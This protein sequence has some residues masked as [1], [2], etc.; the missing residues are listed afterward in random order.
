MRRA[1]ELAAKARGMTSPNPMVGAVLVKN[2]RVIGEGYHHGP[3]LPHAEIDAIANAS[4]DVAGATIYVTLEPCCHEGKTP[5]CTDALIRHKI[6]RVVAAT[7]DPNP[8]VCK[9]GFT[10]LR[11][12]G[13]Q[14]DVGLCE[15]EA[16]LLNEVFITSHSLRRPFIIAKW[17]MT[18]DGKIATETGHSRWITND[19]SRGYVHE[20]RSQVDAIMVGIGTVLVDNP[21]LNV[22][23]ENYQGRQPKCIIMDGA[24]R[25]P[26][27][28][29]CLQSAPAGCCI[30][31]T[32]QSA[33]AEKVAQLRDAGHQVLVLRGRRGLLDVRDLIRELH[34]CGIQSILAE[35]GSG[36]HGNFFSRQLVDKVVAFI[37]P[38]IVG[39][40][41]AKS[42]ISGWGVSLMNKAVKLEHM[43]TRMFDEDIC[44]E[45][46]VFDAY[47][48]LIHPHESG[49]SSQTA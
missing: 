25:I 18:L 41:T 17:A 40:D 26:I 30:I 49:A 19:K 5:P 48:R 6:S 8:A 2:G 43:Q 9:N 44:V 45:G 46:Y 23:L 11:K 28:S 24:L 29:K 10:Q 32:T 33:P 31:A 15:E 34:N 38:K 42:P 36:L 14:V 20:L 27:R 1:L 21:M 39:G 22:R 7:V 12:A 4:E 35:G 13:I 37:A 3:G 47:N 16:R